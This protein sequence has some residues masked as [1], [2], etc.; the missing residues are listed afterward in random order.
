MSSLKI[1]NLEQGHNCSEFLS[2]E[3]NVFPNHADT[4]Y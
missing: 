3:L 2:A 4:D 1:D